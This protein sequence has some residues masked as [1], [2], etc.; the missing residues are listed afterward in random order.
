LPKKENTHSKIKLLL[1][2]EFRNGLEPFPTNIK[3]KEK[4][5]NNK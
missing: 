5:K 2:K 1:K 3:N 4:N